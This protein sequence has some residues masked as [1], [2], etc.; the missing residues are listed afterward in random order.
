M[1]ELTMMSWWM[2]KRML[3]TARLTRSGSGRVSMK[4]PPLCQMASISLR[5][6][7]RIIAAAVRPFQ[8]GGSKP[9]YC[10]CAKRRAFS[11]LDR[12]THHVSA[13]HASH[14]RTPL[15]AAVAADRHEAS[16][17]ATDIALSEL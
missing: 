12:R 10:G 17:R 9:Q 7:A 13:R 16:V 3:P 2:R 14:F 4:F 11:S 5:S 6:D 15:H 8:V 1:L